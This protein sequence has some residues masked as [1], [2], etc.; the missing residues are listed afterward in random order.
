MERNFKVGDKI[1][2]FK[3]ELTDFSQP[4]IDPNLYLYEIVNLA[5]DANTLETLVIYK[6]LYKNKDGEYV[7]WARP[8][9]EFMEPVNKVAYPNCKQ[10]YRFELCE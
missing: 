2:H 1:K 9:F 8:W 6:A 7:T 4:D 5:V 3:R 10:E